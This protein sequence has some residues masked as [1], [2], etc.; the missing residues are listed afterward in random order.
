V[1]EVE[2][3]E[4]Y[5]SKPETLEGIV[6][7]LNVLAIPQAEI[8]ASSS[9]E[10]LDQRTLFDVVDPTILA[11]FEE[12]QEEGQPDIVAELLG[13][14]LN[15]GSARVETLRKAV[16]ESDAHLVHVAAHSLKGISG[17][18]GM[19]RI[20]ALSIELDNLGKSGVLEGAHIIFDELDR[21][22]GCA[23]RLIQSELDRRSNNQ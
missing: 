22:F 10:D 11:S 6:A 3:V 17:N 20:I 16:S 2:A 19:Q 23:R 1:S 13:L 18:L 15:D 8:D 4:K 14:F 9:L 12:L 21:E 7:D 5:I